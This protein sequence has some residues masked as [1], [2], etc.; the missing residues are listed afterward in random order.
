MT[1]MAKA[2]RQPIPLLPTDGVPILVGV[3]CQVSVL[4]RPRSI[5]LFGSALF[6]VVM[7][8][9]LFS[10]QFWFNAKR[11]IL[12]KSSLALTTERPCCCLA[13]PVAMTYCRMPSGF[14]FLQST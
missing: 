1:V 9:Q 14:A 6:M 3:A 7:I 4:T 11:S 12:E 5:Y 2:C 13:S 10:Y 8:R